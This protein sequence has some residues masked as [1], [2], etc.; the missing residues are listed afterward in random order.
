MSK[1]KNGNAPFSRHKPLLLFV[2]VYWKRRHQDRRVSHG[3]HRATEISHYALCPLCPLC[4]L[5]L[6]FFSIQTFENAREK[7]FHHQQG[8]AFELKPVSAS[9]YV[10]ARFHLGMEDRAGVNLC[11]FKRSPPVRDALFQRLPKRAGP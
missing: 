9:P 10:L 1:S 8:A 5:R 11:K 3:D 6:M 2:I 7:C 4:A